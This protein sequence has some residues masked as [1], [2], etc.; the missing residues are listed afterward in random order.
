MRFLTMIKSD[1]SMPAGPPPPALFEAIGALGEQAARDGILL[2]QGGLLPS[3]AGALIRV[4]D[5]RVTVLDGPFADAKELIGGYAMFNVRSKE[6][7]VEQARRFMQVHADHW[8]GFEGVC[9]VR[10]VMDGTD[11]AA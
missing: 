6:E 4:A 7:A 10:Q 3:A 11:G 5:G 8:P 9:E 2:D 1:E